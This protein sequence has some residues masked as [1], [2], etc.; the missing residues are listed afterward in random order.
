MP[1]GRCRKTGDIID[2][3]KENLETLIDASKEVGLGIGVGK[4]KYML[5]CREHNVRQNRD[6]RIA[7]R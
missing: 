6:I 2:T 1:L 5:L 7:N 4:T 3:I